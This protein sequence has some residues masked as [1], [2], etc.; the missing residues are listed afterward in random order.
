M[1]NVERITQC[2]EPEKIQPLN[3]G[4]YYYN[5]DIKPQVVEDEEGPKTQYSFIQIKLHGKPDYK[6]CV[7]QL[8]RKYIDVNQEFDLINTYNAKVLSGQK[9]VDQEYIEYLNLLNT[10]KNNVRKDFNLN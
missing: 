6:R 9:D 1:L 4:Y 3:N 8:I 10:I 2:T 7:Q 5:Y